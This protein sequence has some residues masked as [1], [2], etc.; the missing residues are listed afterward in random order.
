[1]IRI[2]QSWIDETRK[3]SFTPEF[4][5]EMIYKIGVEISYEFKKTT[6]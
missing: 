1:M 6:T 5:Q 2:R 4:V 3:K